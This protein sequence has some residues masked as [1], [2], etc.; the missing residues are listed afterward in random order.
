MPQLEAIV[1]PE[2]S[3]QTRSCRYPTGVEGGLPKPTLQWT[4]EGGS[5]SSDQTERV[6]V[7]NGSIL[8][9]DGILK[10]DEGNYTCTSSNLAGT[11]TSTL[12]ITVAS[13]ELTR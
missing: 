7:R 1:V 4:R 3:P 10:S 13:K 9:F 5:L 12:E 6:H 8:V 2:G 11:V